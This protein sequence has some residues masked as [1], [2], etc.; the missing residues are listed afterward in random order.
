MGHLQ[1]WRAEGCVVREQRALRMGDGY[2]DWWVKLR[3][4]LAKS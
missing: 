3:D 1:T 2:K 4:R